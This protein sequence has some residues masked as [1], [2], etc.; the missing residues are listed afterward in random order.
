MVHHKSAVAL[1]PCMG[2]L[3]HA[4]LLGHGHRRQ[5]AKAWAAFVAA[6]CRRS[7]I[8]ADAGPRSDA[9]RMKSRRRCTARA[10]NRH[11]LLCYL[12]RSGACR[13]TLCD[14]THQE[15]STVAIPWRRP[16][17]ARDA[18]LPQGS[19]R[20]PRLQKRACARR[21]FRESERTICNTSALGAGV[22][23][24]FDRYDSAGFY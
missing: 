17:N 2:A 1:K 13:T 22:C 7:R 10:R 12:R 19:G 3:D 9:P 8:V 14:Q 15:L 20:G 11:L 18:T 6:V 16:R 5:T 4:A 21:S 24:G 23:G